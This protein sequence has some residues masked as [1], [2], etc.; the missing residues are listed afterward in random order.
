VGEPAG[1]AGAVDAVGK[2]APSPSRR[3]TEGTADTAC[4]VSDGDDGRAGAEVTGVG[5]GGRSEVVAAPPTGTYVAAPSDQAPSARSPAADD[6]WRCTSG[7]MTPSRLALADGSGPATS[8]S[9]RV[10]PVPKR[11]AREESVP[12]ESVPH[13]SVPEK[14]A[15]D[16][17]EPK[18]L[19]VSEPELSVVEASEPATGAV[20]TGRSTAR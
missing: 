7:V 17:S 6:P 3:C 20:A 13:D 8:S 2:G 18:T 14:P 9:V 16:I 15:P 12:S 11:S 19:D 1:G 4:G 10:R 5:V